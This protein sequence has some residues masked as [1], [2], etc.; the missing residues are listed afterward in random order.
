MG[1]AS[2]PAEVIAGPIHGPFLSSPPK[3]GSRTELGCSPPPNPVRAPPGSDSQPDL[4]AETLG[5]HCR[6]KD[7][8]EI[9]DAGQ[10]ACSQSLPSMLG[11]HLSEKRS[12]GT[13]DGVILVRVQQLVRLVGLDKPAGLGDAVE[14]DRTKD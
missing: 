3:N 1:S 9:K 12:H 5:C 6:T 4:A 10:C 14:L 13:P 2:A 8:V 11:E 7:A